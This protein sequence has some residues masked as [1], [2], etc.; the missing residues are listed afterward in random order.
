MITVNKAFQRPETLKRNRKCECFFINLD[1]Q[2][3][4][5]DYINRRDAEVAL[6]ASIIGHL[7]KRTDKNKLVIAFV[8]FI[9]KFK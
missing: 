2:T 3:L 7:V 8:F 6:T 9:I 5:R 4:S 1:L